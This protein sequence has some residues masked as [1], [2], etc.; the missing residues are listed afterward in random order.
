MTP[1]LII[2][3]YIDSCVL[4]LATYDLELLP[5]LGSTS[6]RTKVILF[7]SYY[8]TFVILDAYCSVVHGYEQDSLYCTP[9]HSSW[10]KISN[11]ITLQ[12]MLPWFRV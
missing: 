6:Q 3:S 1:S 9:I 8:F 12:K 7:I 5:M 10:D 11:L 2:T 4:F